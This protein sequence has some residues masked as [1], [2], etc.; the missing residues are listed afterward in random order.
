MNSKEAK[1]RAGIEAGPPWVIYVCAY[2]NVAERQGYSSGYHCTNPS[3]E[4]EFGPVVPVEVQP[5]YEP[6]KVKPL[7]THTEQADSKEAQNAPNPT[8]QKAEDLA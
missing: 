1:M 7:R 5:L 3:C 4:N 2:C 6:W 8:S